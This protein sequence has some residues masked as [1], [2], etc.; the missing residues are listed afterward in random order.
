[1]PMAKEGIW[2]KPSV[3]VGLCAAQRF[4]RL[5]KPAVA[6]FDDKAVGRLLCFSFALLYE[7][8]LG[9][10]GQ[11]FP[12]FADSFFSTA[13][14]PCRFAA[15]FAFF[16]GRGFSGTHQWFAVLA[17]SFCFAVRYC[18]SCCRCCCF[19][20]HSRSSG[21]C[22]RW[23]DRCHNCR[24][25]WRGRL[26]RGW[27]LGISEAG[28][29]QASD[30]SRNNLVHVSTTSF[31][32]RQIAFTNQRGSSESVDAAYEVKIITFARQVR[33]PI[34]FLKSTRETSEIRPKAALPFAPRSDRVHSGHGRFPRP[35]VQ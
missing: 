34:S 8:V 7:R 23:L 6:G 27:C 9:S 14:W 12:I 4:C 1:M 19:S 29:K 17:N 3:G 24:F 20:F 10:T 21:F 22:G 28:S 26:G 32:E 31:Y 2:P 35:A 11:R 13:R 16:D 25:G 30:Q 33:T 5:K 15:T 18:G